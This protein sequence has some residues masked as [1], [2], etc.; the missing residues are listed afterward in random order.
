MTPGGVSL[1]GVSVVANGALR[2][3]LL[4]VGGRQKKTAH[5]DEDWHGY[6]SGVVAWVDPDTGDMEEVLTYE[7]PPETVPDER[8]SML[9]K[10]GHLNGQT[11]IACTRTE[12]MEFE[13][14]S[15]ERRTHISLPYFNDIHHVRPGRNGTFLV[16]VTGLDLVA[17][18]SSG[19]DTLNMWN[20]LGEDPWH[21]F[22]PEV[23][24]RKVATT[25]PHQSHPNF[26]FVIGDDFW[27]TRFGQRDAVSLTNPGERIYLGGE[28]PHDGVVYGD[29]VYFTTIDGRVVVA[30][31]GTKE[32]VLDIDLNEI[33]GGSKSLGWCRG[34]YVVDEQRV[35]VG[36]S[37]LRPSVFR[38]N[39][40]WV[41]H[42]FGKRESS[43]A[44]P[45]RIVCYDLSARS[46]VWDHDLEPVGLNAVFSIH[47]IS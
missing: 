5:F 30:D 23:D 3:G 33:D 36:F 7:S 44:R 22:S 14:P 40:Q 41:R 15:F 38:E 32:V 27:V 9:F 28:A 26:S 24:Y 21:R 4:V 17:E 10:A 25:Q 39:V 19:G 43:G 12:I 34:M 29:K 11:L 47:A 45:T 20:V 1:E 6:R 16:V 18:V 42:R 13:L 46:I 2:T 35:V 8:P 31:T 37:R